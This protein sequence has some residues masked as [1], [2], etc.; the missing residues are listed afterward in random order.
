MVFTKRADVKRCEPGKA[1][2]QPARTSTT[3][4]RNDLPVFLWPR[5]LVVLIVA[6]F[7]HHAV[8]GYSDTLEDS[9]HDF[10]SN[11]GEGGIKVCSFCHIPNSNF[12]QTPLWAKESSDKH[13]FTINSSAN[14]SSGM[15]RPGQESVMC[16]SCHDGVIGFDALNGLIRTEAQGVQLAYPGAHQLLRKTFAKVTRLASTYRVEME[17]IAA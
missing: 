14:P 17:I 6:I 10:S 13:G 12:S 15:S 1:S 2:R 5:A 3:S 9:E 11:I 16:L 4:R 7:F 8:L